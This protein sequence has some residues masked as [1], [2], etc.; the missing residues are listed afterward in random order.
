MR[1]LLDES[2]P[3][4]LA[5]ELVGH[6]IR[7]VSQLGWS[8]TKNGEL[9]RRA[10]AEGYQVLITADQNLEYQQNLTKISVGI[11]VL[12]AKSNRLIHLKPLV[13][14]NLKQ[15]EA[16]GPGVVIRVAG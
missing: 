7:T 8:G 12:V 6:D 15:L 5:R 14:Q 3:R 9:L 13:P 11:L 2:V 4:K 1:V 10:G 16:L